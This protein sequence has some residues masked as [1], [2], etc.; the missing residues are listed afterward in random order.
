MITFLPYSDFAKSAKVLDSKRLGNQRAEAWWMVGNVIRGNRHPVV[1]LW[2]GWLRALCEYG[3]KMCE[4]WELRGN[5]DNMWHQFY[6]VCPD[7]PLV[8]PRWLRSH[9][10]HS[11]HRANLVRKDSR[12]YS[13]FTEQPR[14]TYWWPLGPSYD[15][16]INRDDRED[17]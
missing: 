13:M 6:N 5:T 2:H 15:W 1:F 12:H 17:K 3:M 16:R 9:K 10:L 7:E 8:M 4:E 14:E 11:S